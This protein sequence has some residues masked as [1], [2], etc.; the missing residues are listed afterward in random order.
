M[1]WAHESWLM[2]K[3]MT[4]WSPGDNYPFSLL[5]GSFAKHRAIWHF[6]T[7]T[8]LT[9]V[10]ICLPP[11]NN[12]NTIQPLTVGA[13]NSVI[14]S[15]IDRTVKVWNMNYIFE[16][17]H[18]IDRHELPIDSASI[19]TR[20]IILCLQ[21]A[22]LFTG[23]N[24]RLANKKLFVQMFCQCTGSWQCPYESADYLRIVYKY[25]RIKNV[26]EINSN[27]GMALTYKLNSPLSSWDTLSCHHISFAKSAKVIPRITNN[28][29]IRWNLL[30]FSGFVCV[31]L[32]LFFEGSSTKNVSPVAN[33]SEIII[34]TGVVQSW[35]TASAKLFSGFVRCCEYKCRY[36]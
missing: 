29:P 4:H 15:S 30:G 19:C 22:I 24:S 2:T 31:N 35:S 23:Y 33:R 10:H 12:C 5:G 11:S 16:Q 25:K 20:F 7:S 9:P 34:W 1:T 36:S 21:R 18:H 13:W 28:R 3:V 14:T 32:N 8:V 17:V 26:L 27:C 6:S